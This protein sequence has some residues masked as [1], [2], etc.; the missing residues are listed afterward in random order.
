MRSI[1]ASLSLIMILSSLLLTACGQSKASS[2]LD[3][4]VEAGVS[5][6]LAEHRAANISNIR[7]ILHFDIPR[8]HSEPI[9]AQSRVEFDLRDASAPLQLDSV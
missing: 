1:S 5:L 8:D 6:A 7:Y 4:T 2:K 9:K 3:I